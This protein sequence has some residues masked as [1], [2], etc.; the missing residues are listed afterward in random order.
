MFPVDAD[1]PVSLQWKYLVMSFCLEKSKGGGTALS[2]SVASQVG[3][4]WPDVADGLTCHG[5]HRRSPF[6]STD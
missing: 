6:G 3:A 4:G 5:R 1:W 2:H